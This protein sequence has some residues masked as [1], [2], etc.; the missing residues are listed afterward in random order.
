MKTALY[1]SEADLRN[2]IYLKKDPRFTT[3]PQ[4]HEAMEFLFI[5]KGAIKASIGEETRILHPGEIAFASSYRPHCYV[6]LAQKAS[7][8]AEAYVLVMS[9]DYTQGFYKYYPGLTF[10]AFLTDREKNQTIF[11]LVHR[12]HEESQRT[13]LLNVGYCDLMLSRL[14]AVYPL[15]K[16][17]RP[18]DEGLM[19]KLIRYINQHYLESLSLQDL[20]HEFGYT[21]EYISKILSES[22]KRNFREYVNFLRY[23][24]AEELLADP[25]N[26]MTKLEIMSVCGFSSPVTFY[27]YQKKFA[28]VDTPPLRKGKGKLPAY[29][30]KR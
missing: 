7:E 6:D 23:R 26:Q 8:Q 20:A 14:I 17:E 2:A 19:L 27:R 4:F 9:F 16:E 24:K 13:H 12:W 5:L 22:T 25:A 15:K 1:T 18:K 21:V 3:E 11:E 29:H 28:G 30:R 10:D